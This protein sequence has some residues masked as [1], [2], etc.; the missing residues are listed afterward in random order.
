MRTEDPANELNIIPL[1]HAEGCARFGAGQQTCR[2]KCGNQCAHPVPNQTPSDTFEN[3]MRRYVSRRSL[4]RGAVAAGVAVA[5]APRIL[6]GSA[7]AQTTSVQSAAGALTFDEIQ[8]GTTDSIAVPAGYTSS[9]LLR[10][11]D[12]LFADSPAFDP[13]NQT[14]EAQA[15]Q[16]GYNN[17]FIGFLPLPAGSPGTDRALLA[18]NHEYTN[19]ELMFPGFDDE[20]PTRQQVDTEL[21]A[22]GVSVVEIARQGGQWSVIVGSPVNRRITGETPIEITG[23][24]AGHPLLQT[25]EDPTGRR[26]RGTLNNCSAGKTPW[27]TILTREENFNQ[28]FG[29]LNMLPS[30][31]PRQ[32]PHRRYGLTTGASERKWETFHRRFDLA[33][34]PNEP[35]RFGW[36]VEFDPYDP[37]ST[38]KKRTAL[39][40]SKHEAATFM[41]GTDGRVG[42]YMGD[43][44]RFDYVYK[45][46]TARPMNRTDRAANADLLDSGTLYAAK[47]NDDGTGQWL[48]LVQ[49]Q[50]NLTPTNGFASQADVLIHTRQAGD[51]VGATKMDRPEDIEFNPVNNKLYMAMTNNTNRTAEQVDQANPRANNRHGHIIELT[52]DGNNPTSTTFTWEIFMLCGNPSAGDEVYAAGFPTANLAPISSPDNLVVDKSGNLWIFTDGQPGTLRLNDTVY[53]VPTTGP[54]R[55]HLKP[56]LSGVP[57]A[58]PASGDLSADNEALFVSIQHPGEGGSLEE[59]VS[60]FPDGADMPRPSVVMAWKGEASGEKRIGS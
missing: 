51:A 59:P 18:V 47:F 4:L 21:A 33:Q 1:Y 20:S 29:N 44:E 40:R 42:V 12:P 8:L 22:H 56:F 46:V 31:D 43:D 5:A 58:E 2:W 10:W 28:Y 50:G 45:F 25:S 14:P 23:P 26:V 32:A 7:T 36:V 57:G 49:G 17:D 27:G 13:Q 41:V 16:F 15:K 35:F 48:P 19:P 52:E 24:A 39:G 11:G 55:G 3:V 37:S 60:R 9:V 54:E 38:P 53:A 34:E 30:A 6:G